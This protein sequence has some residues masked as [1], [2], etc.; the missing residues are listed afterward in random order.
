MRR[1]EQH[2]GYAVSRL[3]RN[4]ECLAVLTVPYQAAW[5]IPPL[6]ISTEGE[7]NL[8][9]AFDAVKRARSGQKTDRA[10]MRQHYSSD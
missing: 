3:L 8:R 1:G 6:S 5:W 10:G 9:C 4:N 2:V 7:L